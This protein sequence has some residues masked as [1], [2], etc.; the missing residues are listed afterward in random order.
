MSKYYAGKAIKDFLAPNGTMR[1]AQRMYSGYCKAGQVYYWDYSQHSQLVEKG[2]IETF[3][4]KSLEP[5]IKTKEEKK[6]STRR[7]KKSL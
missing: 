3:K 6:T 4:E 5:E 7:K 1:D 2:Y